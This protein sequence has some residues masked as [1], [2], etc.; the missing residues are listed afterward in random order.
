MALFP[1][2]DNLSQSL[3]LSD[4]EPLESLAAR[5]PIDDT[6]VSRYY[7]LFIYCLIINDDIEEARFLLKRASAARRT[8]SADSTE[9]TD[10]TAPL[11]IARKILTS[12]WTKNYVEF[13][14]TV[15]AELHSVPLESPEANM[16]RTL[17]DHVREANYKF[18]SRA[19]L[20]G[21]LSDIAV[22][23]GIPEIDAKE[24]LVRKGWSVTDELTVR[25]P[26][27]SKG[28]LTLHY[29]TSC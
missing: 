7:S 21:A 18:V 1:P 13:F 19:F 23:F 14:S 10:T 22:Y 8:I 24:F 27:L 4:L 3:S 6:N 28:M 29:V 15:E 5:A 2:I 9:V 12:L 25:A 20:S 16:L 26:A 17:A 11:S